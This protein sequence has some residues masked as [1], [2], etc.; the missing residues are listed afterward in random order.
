MHRMTSF[1]IVVAFTSLL[2]WPGCGGARYYTP[3]TDEVRALPP[4]QAAQRLTHLLRN[5]E[6]PAIYQVRKSTE[7]LVFDCGETYVED[8][9]RYGDA[10]ATVHN[11]ACPDNP[12]DIRFAAIARIELEQPTNLLTLQDAAG[13]RIFTIK[14]RTNEEALAL[15][16]LLAWYRDVA[17]QASP[18]PAPAL[19]I[20]LTRKSSLLRDKTNH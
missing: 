17:V 13:E 19:V 5:A 9:G 15:V 10:A 20:E 12:M 2:V 3:R 8:N 11:L 7:R 4:D 16:D 1:L 18:V 14:Q 6:G